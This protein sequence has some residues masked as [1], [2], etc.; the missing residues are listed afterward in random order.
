MKKYIYFL[1]ITI[2]VGAVLYSL[3]IVNTTNIMLGA[4]QYFGIT[5][6]VSSI[7]LGLI[8]KN[9]GIYLT[10]VTLLLGTLNLIAFTPTIESYSFGV[11]FNDKNGIALK[12]Q[13]FSFWTLLVF[14]VVNH[15]TLLALTRKTSKI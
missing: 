13:P 11:S 12:I 3:Y 7:V 14:L 8:R 9:L 1:P 6:I 10:G 5:F 15:K 4:K 2:L